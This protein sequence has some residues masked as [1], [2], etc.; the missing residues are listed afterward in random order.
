MWI[1][2][3]E[4]VRNLVEQAEFRVTARRHFY[5]PP[6]E[7][8]RSLGAVCVGVTQ[9]FLS[10]LGVRSTCS[11]FLLLARKVPDWSAASA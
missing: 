11:Y 4:E 9:Q 2:P 8:W 3:E 10:L 7:G 6:L 1:R 5:D